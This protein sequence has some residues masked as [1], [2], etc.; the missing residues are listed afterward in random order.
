MIKCWFCVSCQEN[1]TFGYDHTKCKTIWLVLISSRDFF[2]F[3]N[4]E[5]MRD[6]GFALSLILEMLSYV[7]HLLSIAILCRC[8]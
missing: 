2:F 7:L 1:V 6:F 5:G 8:V 4:T 3:F